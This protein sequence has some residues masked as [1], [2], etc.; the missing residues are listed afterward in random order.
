MKTINTKGNRLKMKG[1]DLE[2][3][4]ANLILKLLIL[5]KLFPFDKA[6]DVALCCKQFYVQTQ[7]MRQEWVYNANLAAWRKRIHST[8]TLI[9]EVRG[10]ICCVDSGERT[11]STYCTRLPEYAGDDYKP[12]EAKIRLERVMKWRKINGNVPPCMYSFTFDYYFLPLPEDQQ[13]GWSSYWSS[14]SLGSHD[15]PRKIT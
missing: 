1:T 3:E 10:L 2:M 14:Y 7:H 8:N 15:T 9:K 13:Q 11:F 6:R 4:K 5:E 12:N